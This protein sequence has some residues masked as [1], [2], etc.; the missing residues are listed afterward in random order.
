MPTGVPSPAA[1]N[2]VPVTFYKGGVRMVLVMDVA[3]VVVFGALLAFGWKAGKWLWR[4][5]VVVAVYAVIL[6]YTVVA[7]YREDG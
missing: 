2:R 6:V 3:T 1:G 7:S 5:A 4:F